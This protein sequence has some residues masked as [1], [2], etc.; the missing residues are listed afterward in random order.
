M[1]TVRSKYFS[2]TH[3]R[4]RNEP[5]S[6]NLGGSLFAESAGLSCGHAGLADAEHV[7]A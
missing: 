2:Q 6:R 1:M 5:P 3:L 4:G 7:G